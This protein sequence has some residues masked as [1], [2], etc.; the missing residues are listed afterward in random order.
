MKTKIDK[1]A[2]IY[3]EGRLLTQFNFFPAFIKSFNILNIFTTEYRQ[4]LDAYSKNS[5][6]FNMELFAKNDK[7]LSRLLFSQEVPC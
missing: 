1:P 4:L 7:C 5:E 6:T 2:N 3:Y